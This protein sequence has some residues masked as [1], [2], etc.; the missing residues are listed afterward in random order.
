MT[1]HLANTLTTLLNK[2]KDTTIR[3]TLENDSYIEVNPSQCKAR[4][5]DN[6]LQLT[7]TNHITA[8]FDILN[9]YIIEEKPS[10]K[11]TTLED[12]ING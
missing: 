7:T 2:Q 5:D 8:Y 4:L 11:E 10:N 3:I 12:I 6:I 9:V 1:K